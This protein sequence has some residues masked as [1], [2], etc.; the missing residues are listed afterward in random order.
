MQDERTLIP[1]EATL[2][3]GERVLVLAPHPDDE[4]LGCGGLLAQHAQESRHVRV[5]IATDGGGFGEPGIGREAIRETRRDETL[6][7]LERLGISDVRFLDFADRALS[8]AVTRLS[9][10]L[11]AEIVAYGPDLIL[12]PGPLEIHPDHRAASEALYLALATGASVT[13][14]IPSARVAFFEVSQPLRP[15]VL[16]DISA[17][18]ALK[19]T[20]L[21]EHRSQLRAASYADAVQGLN[22]YRALTLGNSV[23]SAE[24]YW[25]TDVEMLRTTSW[26]ELRRM[27]GGTAIIDEVRSLPEV[28]V[29]IRTRNRLRLLREAIDSV[30]AN[31]FP[32]RIVV[33]N[34]GGAAVDDV[35]DGR[36]IQVVSHEDSRGPGAAMNS[37]VQ[38]ATTSHVAFLDDDDLYFT[39]HLATIAGAAAEGVHAGYYTDAVSIT[40]EVDSEGR[41]V[42]KRRARVYEQ[43]FDADLLRL[44]NYVPITAMLVRRDS[45]FAAGGFAEDMPLFEDWD[46]LL[47][48]ASRGSFLRIPRATVA[49]RHFP[50]AGSPILSSP[51]GSPAYENARL[52]VWDRNHILGDALSVG[53]GVDRMRAVVRQRERDAAGDLGL[54]HETRQRLAMFI[55]TTR[56]SRLALDE[57]RVLVRSELALSPRRRDRVDAILRSALDA[58]RKRIESVAR[59]EDDP[60]EAVVPAPQASQTEESASLRRELDAT[61][62]AL[63]D[64]HRSTLWKV[65]SMYWRVLH[66]LGVLK[67]PSD[68]ERSDDRR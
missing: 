46:F 49:I 60:G 19:Q 26:E 21:A 67:L 57:A 22:R 25:V 52:Q 44:T 10:E 4:L 68:A 23:V 51:Q 37:G 50:G 31:D 53:R 7:G 13:S 12:A 59:Y 20:A 3:R 64:I 43:D 28:T 45:Y 11:A 2:L 63:D 56:Q 24:A 14:S 65:G 6:R 36:D 30:V 40:Y 48:L 15:N 62:K 47:R 32:A 33:V 5:L 58:N 34:D 9:G 35:V 61:K 17:E 16:V 55:R 42:E 8:G 18:A 27:V 41:Y 38:A 66:A 54:L 39:E 29:V 1:Y